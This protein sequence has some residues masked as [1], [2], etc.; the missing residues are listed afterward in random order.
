[1]NKNF[2]YRDNCFLCNSNKNVRNV[3]SYEYTKPE[4]MKFLVERY[5]EF[6]S[7]DFEGISFQLAYCSECNF[8][9]QRFI[10][11]DDFYWQYLYR[12]KNA[13]KI[14]TRQNTG[15]QY[16]RGKIREIEK[17]S[18]VIP[19]APHN[20]K[21]LEFG[22]GFGHWLLLAKAFGYQ[23]F[24]IEVKKE[25]VEYARGL[26]LS[27][28]YSIS[29]LPKDETFDLIF[30]EAVFEHVGAPV[31]FVQQLS[32]LLNPDGV[33]IISIPYGS[34]EAVNKKLM[35]RYKGDEKVP[36]IIDPLEHINVFTNGSIRRLG[37][38]AGLTPLSIPRTIM[39]FLKN[40]SKTQNLH[41]LQEVIKFVY[42][43]KFGNTVYY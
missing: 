9:F 12:E 27:V 21:V 42:L 25:R 34:S 15:I 35:Y 3:F 1:M 41:Y 4:L 5:G 13:T 17:I 39:M 32:N 19:K 6:D 2:E 22:S 18:V 23:C 8:Y 31:H 38:Q 43:Q 36:K 11:T 28:Y 14:P 29:E 37:Q 40:I 33:M 30:S 24:G 10:P 7:K 16:Y 20:V 26:G